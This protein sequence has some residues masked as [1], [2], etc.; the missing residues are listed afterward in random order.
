MAVNKIRPRKLN[1]TADSR[2]RKMD[3]MQDAVNLVSTNDFRASG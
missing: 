3:E 1:A 2:M